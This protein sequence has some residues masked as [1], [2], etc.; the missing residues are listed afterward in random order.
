M[1]AWAVDMDAQVEERRIAGLGGE[2]G[3]EGGKEGER[4]GEREGWVGS[5]KPCINPCGIP[6]SII[7]SLDFHLACPLYGN[8]INLD[9]SANTAASRHAKAVE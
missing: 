4:E 7:T 8:M 1:L 2:G 9:S 6:W 3:R 5:T